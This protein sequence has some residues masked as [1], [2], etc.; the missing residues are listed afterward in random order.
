MKETIRTIGAIFATGVAIV[1]FATN[2][3]HAPQAVL[4]L[5]AGA[6][7]AF[8][9]GILLWDH[10]PWRRIWY[11]KQRRAIAI[12][13]DDLAAK[14]ARAKDDSQYE[15]AFSCSIWGQ[16]DIDTWW[17][18][19]REIAKACDA[20]PPPPRPTATISS[21]EWFAAADTLDAWLAALATKLR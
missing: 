7:I 2:P 3:Y 14:R 21:R 15:Q 20:L 1:F 19:A 4:Y 11:R 16:S 5:V 9:V 6:G 12:L 18:D 8:G 17:E 10:L 13:R